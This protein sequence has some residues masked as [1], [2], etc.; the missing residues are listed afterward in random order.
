MR[1]VRSNA[2][3]VQPYL[4]GLNNPDGICLASPGC[5]KSH[6]KTYTSFVA[7]PPT[8]TTFDPYYYYRMLFDSEYGCHMLFDLNTN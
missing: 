8:T 1:Q 3:V 6:E 2:R 5:G 4:G 7:S